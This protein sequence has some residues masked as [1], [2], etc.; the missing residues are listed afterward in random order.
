MFLKLQVPQGDYFTVQIKESQYSF[1]LNENIVQ[2]IQLAQQTGGTLYI[3]P[4]LIIPLIYYACFTY[5][6]VNEHLDDAP[7][8]NKY[9]INQSV[10]KSNYGRQKIQGIII[11]FSILLNCLKLV[12]NKSF[13]EQTTF[14][15]AFTFN[16]Y[17]LDNLSS[18]NINEAEQLILQSNIFLNGDI[19]HKIQQTFWESNSN[20]STIISAHYWLSEQILSYFQNNL[21]LIVGE[22]TA[23]IYAAILALNILPISLLPQNL[24]LLPI[25]IV[26]MI[27]LYYIN[28]LIED[29]LRNI[30]EK[31]WSF[32]QAENLNNVAWL[33]TSLIPTTLTIVMINHQPSIH[34]GLNSSEEWHRVYIL[35]LLSCLRVVWPQMQKMIQ[36]IFNRL[37]PLVGKGL[38][39]LVSFL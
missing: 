29:I 36:P 10:S 26:A 2:Q 19:F 21:S 35:L 20:I 13:R 16:S 9:N 27:F 15:S 5:H 30:P 14:Q 34:Q 33:I 32:L 11:I 1:Y 22:I 37:L 17:Y 24:A 4:Q 3:P 8:D 18:D 38:M 7:A 23:L 6:E 12:F 28:S 31:R 39:Y 25:L